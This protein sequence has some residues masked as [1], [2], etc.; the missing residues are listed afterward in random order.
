MKFYIQIKEITV[1]T[2]EV[3]YMRRTGAYGN[4]NRELMDNFKKWLRAN[5]LYNSKTTIWAIPLDNPYSTESSMCRY[6]VCAAKPKDH[7]YS[8][9]EIQT[10]EIQGGKYIV[11]LIPHTAESVM[12]AW[13]KCFGETIQRKCI[14]DTSRPVMECYRKELVDKHYCELYVPIL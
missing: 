12:A 6:D 2:C 10:R 4:K 3:I 5:H 13:Q 14:L 7:V 8:S 1:P 9:S 11:F